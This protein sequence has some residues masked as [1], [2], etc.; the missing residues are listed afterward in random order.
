MAKENGRRP[1]AIYEQYQFQLDAHT[2]PTRRITSREDI[3]ALHRALEPFIDLPQLRRLAS[4]DPTKLH[5][6]IRAEKPPREVRQ[7]LETLTAILR[8]IEREQ[9]RSPG[10]AAALL[11]VE[12]SH[13]DQEEL[14]TLLLD[15]KSRLLGISTVYRGSLNSSMVRIG[16][17]YKE[18]LRVNSA[19]IIVAHNHPSGDPAPS[20]EDVLVTHQIV[21]AG[22]LLD[23][24]CLDHLVIGQGKWVSMREQRLGFP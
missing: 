13:L 17:V 19:A 14:R 10:D 11:M 22:R 6:A 15:T 20:P 16:E 21:E 7:L 2:Q 9:I 1:Q 3:G 18:A 5:A 4:T 23:I 8:P 12:M 24:E